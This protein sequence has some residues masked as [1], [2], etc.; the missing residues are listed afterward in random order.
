MEVVLKK[1]K[2]GKSANALFY[3][4]QGNPMSADTFD[5]RFLKLKASYLGMLLGTKGRYQDYLDFSQTRWRS[6]IGRG[7]FT[8]M[9]LDVG[10]NEKQTAVLRGDKSTKSMEDYFEV[11]SAT[12]NIHKALT[13]L[14]PEN[15]DK[16]S[17]LNMPFYYKSWKEV[18]EAGRN[19]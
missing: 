13:L 7:I 4:S 18:E 16:V 5:K 15:S 14:S 9:C 10:Y 19:I 8:N 11:I 17:N 6:H 2:N 3:D 12:Y 1:I